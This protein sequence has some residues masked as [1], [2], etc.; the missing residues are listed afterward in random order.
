MHLMSLLPS[1][2][3]WGGIVSYL[4]GNPWLFVHQTTVVTAEIELATFGL[5]ALRSRSHGRAERVLDLVAP[6]LWAIAW[7]FG[8]GAMVLSLEVFIRF[9]GSIPSETETQL[10]SGIG[11]FL[12]G[13]VMVWQLWPW[14]KKATDKRR[15][16]SRLAAGLYFA[17][18]VQF[19]E[20]PWFSFQGQRETVLAIVWAFLIVFISF[21]ALDLLRLYW[22]SETERAFKAAEIKEG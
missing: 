12:F 1:L 8:L 19:F 11:H 14:W 16:W 18:Q 10:T 7:I 9:H 17:V 13:A 6:P 4:L 21:A 5:R 3:D 15:A 20:P 2:T 22:P